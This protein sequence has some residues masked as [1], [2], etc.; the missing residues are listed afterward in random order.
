MNED[1]GVINAVT[2]H[3]KFRDLNNLKLSSH[4]SGDQII[5]DNLQFQDL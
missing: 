3:H 5:Q 1:G 2:N 4:S